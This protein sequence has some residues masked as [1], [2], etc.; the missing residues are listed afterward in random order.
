LQ[1]STNKFNKLYTQK[2]LGHKI[3]RLELNASYLKSG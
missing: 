2:Q 3:I 1:V